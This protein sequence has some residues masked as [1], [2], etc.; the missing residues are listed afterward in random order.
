MDI[1][2]RYKERKFKCLN[3]SDNIALLYNEWVVVF[4]FSD[5][6]ALL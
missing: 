3:S 1:S 4:N 5:D 6:I 2:I